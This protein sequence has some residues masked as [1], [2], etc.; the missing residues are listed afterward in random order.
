M[1]RP[2]VIPLSQLGLEIWSYNKES[3]IL[4]YFVTQ[5]SDKTAFNIYV[6]LP[7]LSIISVYESNDTLF[8]RSNIVVFVH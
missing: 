2:L 4:L 5:M 6:M 1:S 3:I 7:V 8:D